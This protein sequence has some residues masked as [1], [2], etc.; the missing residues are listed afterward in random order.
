MN[1]E[2]V[3]CEGEDWS[4]LPQYTDQSHA[5]EHR[6]VSLGVVNGRELPDCQFLKKS[7]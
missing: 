1:L 2:E 3:V 5:P 4:Q 6:I 7:G